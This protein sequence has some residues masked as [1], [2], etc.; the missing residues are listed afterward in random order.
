MSD[1]NPQLCPL[2]G[3]FLA[4]FGLYCMHAL[5]FE[6]KPSKYIQRMDSNSTVKYLPDNIFVCR[7]YVVADSLEF[8]MLYKLLI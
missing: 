1:K 6:N 2:I 3:L 8:Q 7:N 5:I 4:L